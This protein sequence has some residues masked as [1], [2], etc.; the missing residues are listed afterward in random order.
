MK[1]KT[2]CPSCFS[3][4]PYCSICRGEGFILIESKS[5]KTHQNDCSYC[6]GKGFNIISNKKG[7]EVC[8]ECKGKGKISS[9]VSSS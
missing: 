3:Q 9:S 2:P 4:N 1:V 7:I 5:D 6:K 8:P